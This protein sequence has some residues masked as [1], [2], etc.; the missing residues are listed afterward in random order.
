M[1]IVLPLIGFNSLQFP[2]QFVIFSGHYS[3]IYVKIPNV[4][5]SKLSLLYTIFSIRKKILCSSYYYRINSLPTDSL[6][7]AKKLGFSDRQIG[8]LCGSSEQECR[9]SRLGARIIP[10]VKQIDTMAAEYPAVTNYL[11][12]TYNGFEHDVEFDDQGTIVLG[13]GPYHIGS[14]VEFD[15]C[16]VSAIRTLRELKKKT[17]RM[18][19]LMHI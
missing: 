5:Y 3:L 8:M 19:Y 14:S 11:Y 6:V 13:C 18:S 15:W 12:C 17:V 7:T 16:A 2:A 10:S 1:S 4:I 9:K